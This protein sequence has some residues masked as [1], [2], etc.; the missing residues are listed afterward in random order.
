MTENPPA[1]YLAGLPAAQRA[2]LARV[3]AGGMAALREYPAAGT[4]VAFLGAGAPAPLYPLW[5]GLIGQLVDAAAGRLDGT[6]AAT[7]RA[8]AAESP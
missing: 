5:N 2:G 3:N 7:C 1:G 8:M 6:E 4:A